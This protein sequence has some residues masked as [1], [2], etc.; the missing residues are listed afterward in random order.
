M[1]LN[2]N[3]Y[4]CN[5]KTITIFFFNEDHLGRELDSQVLEFTTSYS[6]DDLIKHI[7]ITYSDLLT[8]YKYYS[9]IEE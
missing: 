7:N 2:N 9:I 1:E 6:G 5:M 3:H 4:I 8:Q